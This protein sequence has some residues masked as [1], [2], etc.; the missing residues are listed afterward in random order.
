MRNPTELMQSILTDETA[1][2]IIDYIPPVYGDSYVG[3]WIIQ[4]IGK[5][6]G[7]VRHICDTMMY[8]TTPATST[9]LLDA[10][11][12]RYGL[13][14]DNSLTPEQRRARII[15]KRM[16]SG[17]C[18][19]AV[20]AAAVSS[21]M[22]GIQVDIREQAGKNAFDVLIYGQVN[23][24]SPAVEVLN[25]MKPAHLIYTIRIVASTS[26]TAEANVGAGVTCGEKFKVEVS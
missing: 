11:E 1:Q 25:R 26:I 20:M 2:E 16:S 10:M 14:K 9:L 15:R 21:A 5:L 17:P 6:L 3:L 24:L 19:P 22:G 7:E 8:E 12:S 18:N 4:A 23:D 13:Q